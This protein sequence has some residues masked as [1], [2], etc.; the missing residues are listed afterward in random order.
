MKHELVS[1]KDGEPLSYAVD[2]NPALPKVKCSKQKTPK[3]H[4]IV[5]LLHHILVRNLV[6]FND[7]Q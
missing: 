3:D 5:A 4:L 1:S 7:F 6:M 2:L